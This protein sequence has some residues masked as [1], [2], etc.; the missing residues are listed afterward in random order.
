MLTALTFF[1]QVTQTT[2]MFYFD[3]N[4]LFTYPFFQKRYFCLSALARVKKNK[5]TNKTKTKTAT[6]QKHL[7]K[8]ETNLTTRLFVS[9]HTTLS[10][11]ATLYI[12][13]S[14]GNLTFISKLRI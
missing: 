3:L 4:P 8:Q 6:K 5:Q 10:N 9:Q 1:N 7:Q 2:S 11:Q 12:L 14:L 13:T